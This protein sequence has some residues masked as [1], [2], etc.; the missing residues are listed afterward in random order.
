[1]QA[2][3]PSIENHSAECCLA[4]AWP[5]HGT[6][7]STKISSP[8]AAAITG[9]IGAADLL[10]GLLLIK[11]C[12]CSLTNL[13]CP[14]QL[15][16]VAAEKLAHLGRRLIEWAVLC[17]QVDGFQATAVQA[18]QPSTSTEQTPWACTV[19]LARLVG[20]GAGDKPVGDRPARPCRHCKHGIAVTQACSKLTPSA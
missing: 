1:M 11:L 7:T 12:A 14:H 3:Q 8:D 18:K 16:L 15:L 9:A 10:Y 5:V 17:K 6:L 13:L 19:N 2:A 4:L 20:R